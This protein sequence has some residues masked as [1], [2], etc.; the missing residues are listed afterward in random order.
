MVLATTTYNA[1]IFPKMREFIDHLTGRGYQNRFVAL[2]ENG[3][4]APAAAKGM[5]AMFEKSKNLT[6]AENT[7]TI[8]STLNRE[9]TAQLE[10]L[11]EE[12]CR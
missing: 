3:T 1:D 5:K 6:F 10:A 2:I 12:L 7:V 9:S 4:W 11:A 8:K